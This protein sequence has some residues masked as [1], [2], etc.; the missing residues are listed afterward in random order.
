MYAVLLD[1]AHRRRRGR[2]DST[3]VLAFHGAQLVTTGFTRAQIQRELTKLRTLGIIKR[4]GKVGRAERLTVSNSDL[5]RALL[6]LVTLID[7]AEIPADRDGD[8]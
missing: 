7:R 3:Q 6:R 8:L 5:A 1:L 2:G 4:A